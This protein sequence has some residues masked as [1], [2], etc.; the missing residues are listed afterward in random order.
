M[1]EYAELADGE[2]S[3]SRLSFGTMRLD[4]DP[5]DA[6]TWNEAERALHAAI[7]GGVNVVHSNSSWPTYPATCGLLAKH[8][9]R[10]ELHHI[11]KVESPDYDDAHFEPKVFRE[12]VENA[13]RSL[14]TERIAVV[15]H[16]QRGPHCPKEMAYSAAGDPRRIA[17]L[18]E[19]AEQ[20]QEVATELKAAGKIGE[21]AT[22]PHTVGFARS[23]IEEDVYGSVVHFYSIL[24]PEMVPLL[25]D[26]AARGKSLIGLRPLTQGMTTD[27]RFPR[28]SIEPGDKRLSDRYA[29]WY[30]RLAAV[31]PLLADQDGSLTSVALRWAVTHPAV[32]TVAVSMNNVSQV[33]DALAAMDAGPLDRSL[34][35]AVHAKVAELPPL[36]KETLFG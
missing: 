22:F 15:Q 34:V 33:E 7:E 29:R 36:G 14:S 25:D 5:E 19:I 23:A 6:A 20:V 4:V 3:A 1:M 11:I 30:E 32:A 16:L 28:Q 2:I 9:R 12:Q 35:T 24:E 31:A 10:G 21:V 27:S 17:A 8:P 26:L 13:L 18:P